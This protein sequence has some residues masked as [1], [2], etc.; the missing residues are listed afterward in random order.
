MKNNIEKIEKLKKLYTD[1][2]LD[3]PVTIKYTD[4]E[5][6]NLPTLRDMLNRQIELEEIA[7]EF[8]STNFPETENL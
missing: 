4:G 2:E 1:E 5:E 6:I 3:R 8:I 7:D